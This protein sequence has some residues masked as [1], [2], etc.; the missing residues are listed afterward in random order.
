MVRYSKSLESILTS[1]SSSSDCFYIVVSIYDEAGNGSSIDFFFFINPPFEVPYFHLQILQMYFVSDGSIWVSYCSR[2]D[3]ILTI[4]GVSYSIIG[5]KQMF[6]YIQI[7][8]LSWSMNYF[9]IVNG[10][11]IEVILV[12]KVVYSITQTLILFIEVLYF[13]LRRWH[14]T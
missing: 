3:Y 13:T 14:S 8:F 12:V 11:P 6:V 9:D 7:E 10:Y 2:V 4:F 5:C 1:F